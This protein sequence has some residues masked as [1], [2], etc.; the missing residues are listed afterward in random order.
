M[1]TTTAYTTFT[2]AGDM[3]GIFPTHTCSWEKVIFEARWKA[4]FLNETIIVKAGWPGE[5]TAEAVAIVRPD[6]TVY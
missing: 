2:K 5:T 4:G 6:G 1:S 3:Q